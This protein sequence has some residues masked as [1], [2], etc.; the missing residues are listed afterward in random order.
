[1]LW[2]LVMAGG[3]GTRLWPLSTPRRPKPILN[4]LPGEKTLLEETLKRLTPLIPSS[5][6]LIICH[7]SQVS[8]L[9]KKALKVPRNQVIGEPCSR[10]TAPT[11][12]VGT[13]W[14]LKLDPNAMILVLPADQRIKNR[15]KFQK[16]IKT[17]ARLSAKTNSF[18][19]FGIVPTFP[20]PSYGYIKVGK[21]LSLKEFT[22]RKIQLHWF[23]MVQLQRLAMF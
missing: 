11:V 17:A 14:I 22:W 16:A 3:F 8:A 13:A 18:S 2:A 12:G 5:R 1:M 20:S 10:N 21:K 19:I 4:L 23:M 6:T 7:E 9:R 15:R